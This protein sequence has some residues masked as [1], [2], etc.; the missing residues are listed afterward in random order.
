MKLTPQKHHF[1]DL[2]RSLGA[3]PC[4]HRYIK[5]L[6]VDPFWL[7]FVALA[8]LALALLVKGL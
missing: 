4:V 5:L 7:E 6:P 8:L 3:R 1:L 2:C